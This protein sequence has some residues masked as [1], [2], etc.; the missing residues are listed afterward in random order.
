MPETSYIL[1]AILI[2]SLI[3]WALRAIPFAFLAPM[4]RSAVLPYLNEY[5]PP[6]V[7][8]ILVFYTVRNTP[9]S[10]TPL[11]IAVAAGLV[12]T[13]GLHLWR[14]NATLSILSGTAAH[15][16]LASTLPTWS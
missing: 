16:I 12:T 8:V 9:V 2:S 6:G 3:T 11:N 13:A 15:V 4:R 10:I 1:A 7:L 14:S 5:M